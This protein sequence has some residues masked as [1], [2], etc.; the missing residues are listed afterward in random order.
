MRHLRKFE[1]THKEKKSLCLFI[2]PRIHQDTLNTFWNSVKYEYEGAKQSIIPI[3][4]KQVSFILVKFKEA[5][6][7]GKEF[8]NEMVLDLLEKCSDLKEVK[9]SKGWE[10][11]INLVI[12][13]W[14]P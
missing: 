4:L 2:A 1:D 10:K 5:L 7:A 8:K 13:N 3:N 11:Q 14:M 6:L 12:D 9:T